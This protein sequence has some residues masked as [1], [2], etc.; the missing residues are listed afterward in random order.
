M[1]VTGAVA[2]PARSELVTGKVGVVAV[3]SKSSKQ[4]SSSKCRCVRY[5]IMMNASVKRLKSDVVEEGHQGLVV[6][7]QICVGVT[8][9][10]WLM[11]VQLLG[12]TAGSLCA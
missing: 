11:T 5:A 3:P 8:G 10:L 4:Q 7:A 12:R 2:L 6:A 9:Q 1:T